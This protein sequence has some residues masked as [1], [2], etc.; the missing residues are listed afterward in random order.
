MKRN[1]Q[2][3]AYSAWRKEIFNRDKCC[4]M[5]GCASKK[6]LQAH[7]IRRWSDASSLRYDI[8]NGITLCSNCH[9]SIRNKESHYEAL[10]LEI[11][12]GL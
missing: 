7:H 10:F 9:L 5:P 4:M 11:I 8:K 1:Y 6:K 3:P 12:N 2:D